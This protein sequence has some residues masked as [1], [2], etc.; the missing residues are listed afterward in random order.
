[1]KNYILFEPCFSN[2]LFGEPVCGNGLKE[3]GEECDCGAE[4]CDC[5][6]HQTCKL[7]PDAECSPARV[8]KK[9]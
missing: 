2:L 5:C 8:Q 7:L 4:P 3:K 1:M 6:D 9:F